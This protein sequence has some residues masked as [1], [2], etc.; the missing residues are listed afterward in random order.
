MEIDA[1]ILQEIKSTGLEL[2]DIRNKLADEK[3]KRRKFLEERQADEQELLKDIKQEQKEAEIKIA[4]L[5]EEVGKF[6]A[7]LNE[8]S[9]T[10]ET[11]IKEVQEADEGLDERFKR[12]NLQ[13]DEEKRILKEENNKLDFAISTLKSEKTA[14]RSKE[15]YLAT[16]SKQL[17]SKLGVNK[18]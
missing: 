7:I 17:K 13:L 8:T 12:N 16:I 1:K 4:S 14:L 10:I 2:L 3:F 5:F 11:A 18:L 6:Q 9:Q 15:Q